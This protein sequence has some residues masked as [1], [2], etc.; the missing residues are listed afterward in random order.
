MPSWLRHTNWFQRIALGFVAATAVLFVYLRAR[1]QDGSGLV[2]LSLL[3]SLPAF[4][5]QILWRVRNRLLITYFLFGVIPLFLILWLLGTTAVLLLGQVAAE[6][7]RHD[8]EARI[9]TVYALTHDL[10][11]AASYNSSAALLEKIRNREPRLS[12]SLQLNGKPV[13]PQRAG[14][15]FANPPGW[16]EPGF[17]GIF[18]SDRRYYLG[19][20]AADGN[21]DVFTYLPLDDETLATITPRAVVAGIIGADRNVNMNSSFSGSSIAVE[22]N[23][24]RQPVVSPHL[25]QPRN[26]WDIAVASPLNWEVRTS[27]G[28]PERIM[29]PV[30]SRPSRLLAGIVT[31]LTARFMIRFLTIVCGFLLLV[32]VVSLVWSILLTRTITR[33]VNDLYQG[34]QHV[35]SGD[36]SHQIPVR[37]ADQLSALARSFNS[38]TG[39]IRH[40]IG[41]MRKKQSWN[42]NWKSRGRYRP[43]C[44]RARYRSSRRWKWQVSV[45]RAVLSAATITIS[46]GWTNGSQRSLSA[47]YREKEYRRRF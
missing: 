22:V 3:V 19:A 43:G 24:V 44:F 15:T 37:G 8:L 28:K 17:K 6:R 29:F 7:V 47:M 42:P 46:C 23:G 5:K 36:F 32:E 31:G 27:S 21:A 11:V 39:Q 25:A 1:G 30:L 20:R 2:I 12:V 41:E 14:V 16:L 18:E 26:T 33:S 9:E 45:Y 38:M 35:S 40:F 34:T 13:P 10:A 4:R